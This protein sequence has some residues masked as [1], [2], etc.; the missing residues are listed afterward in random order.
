MCT[1]WDYVN[2]RDFEYLN[3]MWEQEK[4]KE[5]GLLIQIQALGNDLKSELNI[6]IDANPLLPDQSTF[7]KTVYYTPTRKKRNQFVIDPE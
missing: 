4:H 6:P 7:F 1:D 2:V 5:D 3:N